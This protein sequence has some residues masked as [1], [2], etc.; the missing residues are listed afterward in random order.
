MET[1][2]PRASMARA[3]LSRNRRTHVQRSKRLD[4]SRRSS[5]VNRAARPAPYDER[6]APLAVF[7]SH[8]AAGLLDQRLGD[9]E[10]KPHAVL[11][12]EGVG[13]TELGIAEP[14]AA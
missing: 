10:T 1:V 3:S 9:K 14:V 11:T 12:C 6:T 5:T 2:K 7:R 4:L 13:R 8:A